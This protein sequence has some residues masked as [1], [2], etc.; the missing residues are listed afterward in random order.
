[1]SK[2]RLLT[3]PAVAG[4]ILALTALSLARAPQDE[5]EDEK[6]AKPAK[7]GAKG[8]AV[9]DADLAAEVKAIFSDHCF[10]CH[11]GPETTGGR[12]KVLDHENLLKRKAIKPS[13]P[14]ESK[15][16]EYITDDSEGRMPKPP[17]PK[18]PPEKI[19]VV[20]RWIAAGAPNFPQ[21]APK[22]TEKVAAGKDKGS[23]E[24]ALGKETVGVEY[25]LD[26]I[27]ADIRDPRK[28]RRQ[29]LRYVR[30]FS[31]NHI[32]MREQGA[33][34]QLLQEYRE[35]FVKAINHLSWMGGIVKPRPVDPPY[36]TVF[37][38]D[39][40]QL[41]WHNQ[42]YQVWSWREQKGT[43]R[44]AELNLYDLVLLEYPYAAIYD[45]NET[46]DSLLREYIK[47]AYLAR[48]IPYVRMD[49]F[50]SVIT[51]P[52]LYEDLM[53]LP[54]TVQ[55][56]EKYLGVE[57]KY[58]QYNNIAKR[59]GM[60]VSGV[61]K[62][63][64][65][66]ER[67]P[68]GSRPG[69]YWA[70]YDFKTSKGVENMFKDPVRFEETGGEF[71]W[72]L[73]NGLQGYYVALANGERIEAAP[74]EI[75]TDAF[76]ADKTVRNGLACMRCHNEGMKQIHDDIRPAVL[77]AARSQL[78][79]DR[80]EVLDLYVPKEEMDPLYEEDK[81]RFAR[82]MEATVGK[83]PGAKSPLTP[84][85]ERFLDKPL[86]LSD[87]AGELGLRDAK[88]LPS[89]FGTPGFSTLG[90]APLAAR[91]MIRRDAWED[92][93]DS[94][95][96]GLGLGVP[97][98]P[99][100]GLIRQ[101]YPAGRSDVNI[102]LKVLGS[103]GKGFV[104]KKVFT[105]KDRMIVTVKNK[106]AKSVYIELVGTSA[107]GEKVILTDVIQV[108]PG[109]TYR[110]PSEGPGLNIKPRKGKEHVTVMASFK[111][112]HPG[113]L[114][115]GQLKYGQAVSD[116]VYHPFYEVYMGRRGPQVANDAVSMVKRTVE[117]ETN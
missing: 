53:M 25:V 61:S 108:R 72:S 10:S 59:A 116:R 36:N 57:R 91:G 2:L 56:L 92:Y 113:Q 49:W 90:L 87:A 69:H 98:V 51:Q 71:I 39:I 117:F 64:R 88:D 107:H 19:E 9:S 110:Y 62:N 30:Y 16:I 24:E 66:V 105:A 46:F 101:D 96:R 37:A 11:G 15:I 44:R 78:A 81:E 28:V 18:L 58:N 7:K 103:Q 65:V 74:T 55:E 54:Y 34:P 77:K 115:R 104:P 42:P 6:K 94:V 41:G 22:P 31:I 27:L 8:A 40:R 86:R 43:G 106:C 52:P 32:L 85:S 102:E 47:P 97:V 12:V 95:V 89:V 114:L 80:R 5:G 20:R 48:P 93:Y 70:S 14:D 13:K 63:N 111:K 50:C 35:A 109:E 100:D 79:F 21:D 68:L 76:A 112:F 82:A 29:D 75:V 23:K 45:D 3:I 67:H 26:K 83:R 33:T 4:V 1:M 60:A 17:A 99:L 38:V 84:V 73:P